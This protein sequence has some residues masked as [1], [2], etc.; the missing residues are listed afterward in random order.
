MGG[1][2]TQLLPGP[3][4][5]WAAW[6]RHW[7]PLKTD[8]SDR[9]LS[10][11]AVRRFRSW[12]GKSQQ[13]VGPTWSYPVCVRSQRH[14]CV[15]STHTTLVYLTFGPQMVRNISRPL[16][17]T[18]CFDAP[19][20]AVPVSDAPSPGRWSDPLDAGGIR[21]SVWGRCGQGKGQDVESM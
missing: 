12:S 11:G 16:Q 4:N 3:P 7:S 8:I 14:H 21:G 15:C 5:N 13:Y 1:W 17:R 10:G 19:R 20:G 2:R 6:S 18:A 9:S